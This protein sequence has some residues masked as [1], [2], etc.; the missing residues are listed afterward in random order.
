MQSN[1]EIDKLDR[2]ILRILMKDSRT[3][4]LEIARML[5]VS[6]GTI[7]QR[8]ERL[9][10]EGIITGSKFTID[11]KK[12]GYGITALLGVHLSSTKCLKTVMPKLKAI[13]EIT[14]IYYTTGNFSLIIKV[15]AK[16]VEDFHHFLVNKLQQ[17]DEVQSTESFICLDIPH[18]KDAPII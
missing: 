1:Y 15:Y 16:D 8:V 18:H 2:Q 3:P 6:G 14:E 12:L 13:S 11:L 17:I 10:K 5:D 7:H 9:K 4:F